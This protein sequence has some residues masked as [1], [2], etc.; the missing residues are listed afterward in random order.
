MGNVN[1]QPESEQVYVQPEF[2]GDGESTH[3]RLD[4]DLFDFSHTSVADKIRIVNHLEC[5]N[6]F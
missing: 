6:L 4:I 3:I 5:S 2:L 1:V